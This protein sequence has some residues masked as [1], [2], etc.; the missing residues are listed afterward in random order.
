MN[1]KNKINNGPFNILIDELTDISVL[2]FLRLTIMYF[3]TDMGQVI[4]T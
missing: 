3:D 4:L 2:K 1:L